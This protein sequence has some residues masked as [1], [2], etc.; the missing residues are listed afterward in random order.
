MLGQSS[1]NVMYTQFRNVARF[2]SLDGLRF[3][4]IVPVVWHHATLGPMPG[5]L[6]RGPL[7]V[8]LFFTLSGFLITTLLLRERDAHG[9]VSIARFF[10]RRAA[11][12]FPL[13][14]LCLLLTFAFAL[15]WPGASGRFV[16]NLPYF[17][18]YTA[19]WFADWSGPGPVLFSYA[20]SLCT[21][22]QFYAFWPWLFLLPKRMHLAPFVAAAVLLCMDGYVEA[23]PVQFSAQTFRILSSL[24]SPI[25]LGCMGAHLLHTPST[26]AAIAR[27]LGHR[28]SAPLCLGLVLWAAWGDGLPLWWTHLCMSLLVC[29]CALREDN[30]LAQLLRLRPLRHVGKVSYGIYMVHVACLG[31]I[32]QFLGIHTPWLV[33]CAGFPLSVMVATVSFHSFEKPLLQRFASRSW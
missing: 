2:G 4:S 21:E 19:N 11:R 23:H 27:A 1:R 29:T 12:I 8:D 25:A 32:K 26:F 24:S 7:G 10:V 30:G 15:R 33:F 31:S 16:A 14:Y 18:T 3:L 6:G 20:W 5:I 22:E 28:L 9:T 13:Y 17:A